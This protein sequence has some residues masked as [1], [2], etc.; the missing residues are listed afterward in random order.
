MAGDNWGRWGSDDQA[1]AANLVGAD[2]VLGGVGLVRRGIVVPLGQQLGPTSPVTPHRKR[3]ERS[4]TRDG[5]DY[6]AGARRPDGFQFAEEVWSFAAHSG[7][8]MDALAHTWYDDKLY[9]GFSSHG[10]RSTTGARRCGAEQLRPL[11]TRGLLLDLT[12]DG[13]PLGPDEAVTADRL[14]RAA[15]AVG[16]APRSGDVVLV[17][18]GWMDVAGEDA[19]R[20]FATEPGIDLAA[21]RWLADADVV[22]VGADNYAVE[23]QPSTPGT[24]FPAHQL[25]IR[26][27]GVPLIEGMLLSELAAAGAVEFCFV[28]APLP[29]TGGTA[30]PVCPLA[31]L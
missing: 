12:V 24:T 16:V 19:A 22:A 5:G 31:V 3:V 1:G 2:Q 30:S 20:F 15:S 29:L 6:A 18:T 21:A 7:T 27:H 26:D 23:V 25:L 13:G 8:H 28:V 14:Q 4:M 11:V 17:R 9:N 10:T